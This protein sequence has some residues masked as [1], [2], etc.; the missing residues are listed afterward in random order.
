MRVNKSAWEFYAKREREFE[1]SSTI[2][3]VWPGLYAYAHFAALFLR[4]FNQTHVFV[5]LVFLYG[6]A[7][8][9]AVFTRWTHFMYWIATLLVVSFAAVFWDVKQRPCQRG[10][11]CVTHKPAGNETTLPVQNIKSLKLTEGGELMSSFIALMTS[12][13]S[14]TESRAQ[15]LCARVT[16]CL[17]AVRKPWGLKNP[18]I[19]NTL[20]RPLKIQVE[21]WAFLSRNSVNQNPRVDDSQEICGKN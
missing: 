5:F 20:G 18:V 19:Q 11:R 16:S 9:T 14:T 8:S 1:L 3:L 2:I 12:L 4:T 15:P 7:C 10:K 13:C 6:Y 21:N 17:M